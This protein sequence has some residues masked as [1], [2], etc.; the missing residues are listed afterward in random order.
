MIHDSLF[1]FTIHYSQV[2]KDPI[3]DRGK[4]SKKGRL[5]LERRADGVLATVTEGKG[6][7][8][9]DVLREVFR[10]GKLLIDQTFAEIRARAELPAAS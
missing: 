3:T 1:T 4:V 2:F 8:E 6:S 5:T 9:K 10:D 7:A